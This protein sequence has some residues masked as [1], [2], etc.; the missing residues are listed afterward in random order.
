MNQELIESLIRQSTTSIQ[1]ETFVDVPDFS[2]TTYTR[3]V[4]EECIKAVTERKTEY[5]GVHTTFDKG[6][7]D[8]VKEEIVKDIRKQ[9]KENVK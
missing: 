3:L 2:L 4:I 7:A 5:P 1:D 9:F 8:H 6:L